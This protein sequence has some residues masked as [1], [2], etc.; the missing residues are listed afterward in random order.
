MGREGWRLGDERGDQANRQR[1]DGRA[2]LGLRGGR[3]GRQR[4]GGGRAPRRVPCAANGPIRPPR[5][6]AIVPAQVRGGMV[7]LG[8]ARPAARARQTASASLPAARSRPPAPPCGVNR[9]ERRRGGCAGLGLRGGHWDKR[10]KPTARVEI[11]FYFI[12]PARAARRVEVLTAP[13]PAPRRGRPLPPSGGCWRRCSAVGGWPIRGTRGGVRRARRRGAR[14]HAAADNPKDPRA[15]HAAAGGGA[16][17]GRGL[18]DEVG[19]VVGGGD[20]SRK[21]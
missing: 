11:L 20:R 1:T 12:D 2:G 21:M 19:R 10:K 18:T 15:P 8:S 7:T 6:R 16:R 5:R 4:R 17:R 3:C 13:A 9:R 14:A